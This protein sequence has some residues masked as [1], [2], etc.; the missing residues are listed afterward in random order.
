LVVLPLLTVSVVGAA[1]VVVVVA[2]VVIVDVV[3]PV[4]VF[5]TGVV[6][7]VIAVLN[8]VVGVVEIA[9]VVVEVVTALAQDAAS[10]DRAIR[11]IQTHVNQLIL[12]GNRF[13]IVSPCLVVC[14]M[15]AMDYIIYFGRQ[16]C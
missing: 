14:L 2:V 9:V 4:T 3:V 15:H 1:V 5:V 6:V 7:V 12:R 16:Q 11:V 8:V 10:N 13:C